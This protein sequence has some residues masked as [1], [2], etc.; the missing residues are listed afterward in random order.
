[1]G[2]PYPLVQLGFGA[3]TAV[4]NLA[5]PR[6]SPVMNTIRAY[7]ALTKYYISA[8][9]RQFRLGFCFFVVLILGIFYAH[10]IAGGSHHGGCRF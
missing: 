5:L 6:G 7:Y 4:G 8:V 1:M 9:C 10:G 2:D 3:G